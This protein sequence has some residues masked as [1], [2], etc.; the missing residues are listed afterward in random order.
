MSIKQS[1]AVRQSSPPYTNRGV[2]NSHNSHIQNSVFSFDWVRFT[3]WGGREDINPLLSIL[4]V[5]V[6]L[7]FTGHGGL[8]FRQLW[9][10]LNGFQLYTHP[11]DENQQYVSVNLPSKCLQAIGVEAFQAGYSW[12][13]EQGLAG[14][15]W[16]C[17]RLD[18]AFD[19]QLFEVADLRDAWDEGLV[20]C[21]ARRCNEIKDA[22]N[23]KFDEDGKRLPLTD[24]QKKTLG[25]TLY[26]GSRQS[27]SMLRVYHKMDGH[28]FGDEDFTRVELEL[29]KERAMGAILEIMAAPLDQW[30]SVA[31]RWLKGY[32]NV[33]LSWWEQWLDGIGSSWLRLRQRIPTVAS[34]QK[35]L[36][37][38][39]AAAFTTYVTAVSGGDLDSMTEEIRALLVDGQ[40]K[41]S[42]RHREMI[43]HYAPDTSPEFA[44]FSL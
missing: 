26:F 34:I 2:R 1:D 37:S 25:H 6:G 18:L 41:L 35:W 31:A 40:G 17:T 19:T 43:D 39:V 28:S 21:S 23:W 29:K 38:Q 11:V 16:N 4:G 9:Q 22:P 8:G 13:C 15:R 20:D 5:D 10:G 36:Y 30:A 33:R 44:V 27:Q 14:R 42:K 32:I 12:L 7:E 3:F 24:E